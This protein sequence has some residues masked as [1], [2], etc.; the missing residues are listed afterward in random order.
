TDWIV[1]V[2]RPLVEAYTSS[3]VAL[4]MIIA[5]ALMA[6]I[7]MI[8]AR[9]ATTAGMSI[10]K[11]KIATRL[12]DLQTKEM[13]PLSIK[14]DDTEVS[15]QQETAK[16]AMTRESV[17]MRATEYDRAMSDL[18]ES[19]ERYALA[20]RGAKDGLWDWDLIKQKVYYS[21]RWKAIIGHLEAEIGTEPGEWLT[22]VH[23]KDIEQ[24]KLAIRAHLEGIDS[25]FESEHRI[26]HREG[27][28]LWVL[29]RGIAVRDENGV[30]TRLAGV[31]TDINDR[32]R[33]EEQLRHDAL[34]DSLTGLANRAL[35]MDRLGHA[36]ERAKRTDQYKYAV[37]FLDLDQFKAV[38][39]KLGHVVGDKLLIAVSQRLSECIREI[40]TIARL[41]GDEFV[42][43]LED[44]EILQDAT[45]I[46]GRIHSALKPVFI[47]GEDEIF[48]STSI[49]IVMGAAHYQDPEM[50]LRDADTALYRAKELG[51]ARYTVFD[52]D[53]RAKSISRLRIES[54]LRDAMDQQEAQLVY[55]PVVSCENLKI[56][57]L[58]ASVCWR[59][60]EEEGESKH[61][62]DIS[63]AQ[64]PELLLHIGSW[65]MENA[66]KQRQQWRFALKIDDQFFISQKLSKH[67]MQ[68]PDLIRMARKIAREWPLDANKMA[69]EIEASVMEE[70]SESIRDLIEKL[71]SL[72]F[73][74][75]L[76]SFRRDHRT[77]HLLLE[78]PFDAVKI[79]S[80]YVDKLVSGD[81]DR[82]SIRGIVRIA[83]QLGRIAIAEGVETEQ[84]LIQ[85]KALGCDLCQGKY[86]SEKRDSESIMDLLRESF[87]WRDFK[88]DS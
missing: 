12:A 32:K 8:L 59:S 45:L 20:V 13:D 63:L 62:D 79:G 39:D 64:D 77:Q 1:V 27:Y 33:G 84:H 68:N 37:L 6:M 60:D 31:I 76:S 34:H 23:P 72:G 44:I 24:L 29:A 65:A 67:Q 11:E 7:S 52:E 40:D 43:L 26:K 55:E 18:R 70:V 28:Y 19:Q 53:M 22:R 35:F 78:F 51:G 57:G 16:E 56:K 88:H 49:G 10:D 25:H 15:K 82:E 75:H 69:F 42:M 4:G 47:L 9:S 54:R 61:G 74:L 83:H 46:A 17:L 66:C 3:G 71:K 58:H 14:I 48:T 5:G 36:L 21:S 85:V 2:E 81:N 30:A 50:L 38:N 41:G 73:H 80:W 86:I 87:A